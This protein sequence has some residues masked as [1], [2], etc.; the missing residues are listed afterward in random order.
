MR[1]MQFAGAARHSAAGVSLVR[2]FSDCFVLLGSSLTGRGRT[3]HL[4]IRTLRHTDF[5]HYDTQNLYLWLVQGPLP[6]I[7]PVGRVVLNLS[8][9]GNCLKVPWLLRC[10]V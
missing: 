9:S 6:E 4:S 8:L 2:T 10:V 5:T 7:L 3:A 1:E